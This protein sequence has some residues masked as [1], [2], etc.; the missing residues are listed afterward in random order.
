MNMEKVVFF[1]QHTNSPVFLYQ[2]NIADPFSTLFAHKSCW[3][4][5][6]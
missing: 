6:F 4:S 2:S 1:T 3:N 5:W